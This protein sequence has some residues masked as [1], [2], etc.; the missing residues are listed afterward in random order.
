MNKNRPVPIVAR[1]ISLLAFAPCALGDAPCDKGFR[2]TTPAERA[3]VTSVLK[4]MQSALPPA[5]EGW[6]IVVDTANEIS[7][8]GRICMDTEKTPWRYGFTRTYKQV[9][10]AEARGKLIDDQ[11]ANQL[12]AMQA[13]KP[14]LD[15]AQANYQKIMNRITELNK[16]Q[17]YAGAEKLA[18]QLK[19]AEKEYEAILNEVY[20]P[21]AAAATDKE[22]NRDFEMTIRVTAN[23]RSEPVGPGA[24]AIAPPAHA[25]SAQRWHVESELESTDHALYLFGAWTAGAG[26]K[27]NS[28]TRAGASPA[29]AH[30]IAVVVSGDPA[31]VTATA[32]TI[33]FPAFD[34]AVK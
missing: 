1:L 3:Q 22:V 31:R 14:R 23:P 25:K 2:D 27:W 21:A 30:A 15:A 24:K 4:A 12:A 28:G 26:G 8:P 7:V 11:V 34:A 20:D 18:P 17:D 16:K 32:P 10:G 5:P 9:A 6:T 29:A 33:K 13:K 19:A